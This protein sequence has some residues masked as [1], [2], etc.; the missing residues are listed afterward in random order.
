MRFFTVY[1]PWGR[2][3]M[4]LFKFC[5]GAVRRPPDRYLQSRKNDPGFHLYRRS[6]RGD[7]PAASHPPAPVD[8]RAPPP[9]GD[10]LSP[11]A[12]WR[13]VNIGNESPVGLMDFVGAIET[14]TGLEAERNFMEMQQGDVP[15]TFADTALLSRLTGF[16]PKTPLTE[17]VHRFVAWYREYYGV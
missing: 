13:V 8:G 3:D 5:R 1:G 15:A 10:S 14:A 17:G 6:R 11:V 12:A 7:V 9:A 4:A 2:P 16:R